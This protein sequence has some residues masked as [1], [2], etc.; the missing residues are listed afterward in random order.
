MGAI[1]SISTKLSDKAI[2]LSAGS[3]A[4]VFERIGR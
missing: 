4:I 3:G 2:R 1:L